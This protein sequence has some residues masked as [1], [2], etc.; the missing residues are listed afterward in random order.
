MKKYIYIIFIACGLFSLSSCDKD[1]EDTSKVTYFAEISVVGDAVIAS[2][3]GAAF[4]DP[5]AKASENG[6]DI[7]SKIEVSG[8][9]NTDK[10]GI[11][12]IVYSVK[13]TDGIANSTSRKVVVYDKTPSVMASG[14]YTITATSF[15]NNA[16]TIATYGKNFTIIIY[17]KEPGVFVTTDFLGGWYDQRAGYGSNYAASGTFRLDADNTITLL[18]SSV[19]A[20]GDSLAALENASY[21]PSTKVLK[22]QAIYAGGMIFDQ[23]F[24]K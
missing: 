2:E 12:N 11:Y 6:E 19:P 8:S 3:K 23:T 16:G 17:Q 18:S 14:V 22:W 15:R 21:N 10:P 4:N 20:W 24:N 13:N 7:S 1:S 5:G 9:V